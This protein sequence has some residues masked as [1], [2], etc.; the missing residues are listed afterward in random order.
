LNRLPNHKEQS[1]QKTIQ[2]FIAASAL[3]LFSATVMAQAQAPAPVASQPATP[4]ID[5]RQ[6]NQEKRIAQGV[7]S[8]ALT[9]AEAKRMHRQQDRI[10]K[11]EAH[12][13][14]DGV[15]TAKERRKLH[16]KQN[17]TN[18]RIHHQKHDAQHN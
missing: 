10:E 7:A 11:A 2:Q 6:A 4:G 18:K 5:K 9:E 16:K 15:V 3:A 14:A 12:A 1:V 13:K 8:G 17:K